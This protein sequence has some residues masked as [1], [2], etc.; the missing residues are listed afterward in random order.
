MLH[1]HAICLCRMTPSS[2]TTPPR[3]T[4]AVPTLHHLNDQVSGLI[5][6]FGF[7]FWFFFN[8]KSM[9]VVIELAA[10]WCFCSRIFVESVLDL[11][12]FDHQ[13]ETLQSWRR[14]LE[15]MKYKN[16]MVDVIKRVDLTRAFS[17]ISEAIMIILAYQL[18]VDPLISFLSI[19]SMGSWE[20]S[21]MWIV[22]L[23]RSV[24][25]FTY[26]VQYS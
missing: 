22:S 17:M 24:V 2:T 6:E 10:K 4:V 21:K 11:L 1:R 25:I 19:A 23:F 12:Q 9:L 5:F 7:D 8:I 20:E 14:C 3:N 15:W 26:S 13:A 18:S 16:V